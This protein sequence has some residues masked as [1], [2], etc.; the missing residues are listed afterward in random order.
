MEN[1]DPLTAFAE[2]N[3]YSN[4]VTLPLPEAHAELVTVHV[5][6]LPDVGGEPFDF[7]ETV[8]TT[9][10]IIAEEAAS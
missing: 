4:V 6:F 10:R 5:C 8:R 3:E 2:K 9:P 1:F 7:A